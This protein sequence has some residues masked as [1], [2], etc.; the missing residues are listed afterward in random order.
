MLHAIYSVSVC[1][2]DEASYTCSNL[3]R[4][5]S[6]YSE[7]RMTFTFDPGNL[8]AVVSSPKYDAIISTLE[9]RIRYYP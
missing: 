9:R 7:D 6:S 3:E 2:H 1:S 5:C 4:F 8:T